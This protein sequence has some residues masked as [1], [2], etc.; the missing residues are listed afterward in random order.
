M[1]DGSGPVEAGQTADLGS[2]CDVLVIGGGCVGLVTALFSARMGCA[3][4]LVDTRD[5]D[6]GPAKKTS[7][8]FILTRTTVD[9]LRELGAWSNLARYA[10]PVDSL[11][12]SD[13][14][15]TTTVDGAPL[16]FG[17]KSSRNAPLVHVV[18]SYRLL[19]VLNDAVRSQPEI[20]AIR[21]HAVKKIV[22]ERDLSCAELTDGRVLRTKLVVGCDG[23]GSLIAR[24]NRIG[25][26][27]WSF[28]QNSLVFTIRHSRQNVRAAH[29][30]LLPEGP[31]SVLP[32]DQYSSSIM[33]S[34]PPDKIRHLMEMTSEQIARQIEAKLGGLLGT[35]DAVGE[36]FSFALESRIARRF[37]TKRTVLVGD[38]AHVFHPVT[39]QGLNYGFR[40]VAALADIFKA[41]RK[42][43]GV[44]N[45]AGLLRKYNASRR[46]DALAMAWTTNAIVALF[47]NQNRIVASVRRAGLCLLGATPRLQAFL[48]RRATGKCGDF[49]QRTTDKDLGPRCQ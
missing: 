23:R 31:L 44:L 27:G 34:A 7:Q 13:S 10:Y 3:T 2:A 42:T 36:R 35:V 11:H 25:H 39:G 32:L 15:R 17:Q 14:I 16:R 37:S 22:H 12:V 21:G 5:P 8:T 40:D 30:F 41:S 43:H 9:M 26:A 1:L 49:A 45:H 46:L 4:T 28:D 24:L 29:Q 48:V 20:R 18:E 47:N 33:W 38:A 6:L 19:S